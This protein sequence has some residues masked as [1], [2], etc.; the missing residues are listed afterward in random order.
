[1]HFWHY[2]VRIDI[3]NSLKMKNPYV[4]I[5]SFDRQNLFYGVKEISRNQLFVNELVQEISKF[6]AD[7]GSTIVYC[8]TI[9]DVEQVF[10]LLF[11]Y[12]SLRI[13]P[14]SVAQL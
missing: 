13:P 5:G 6:V 9:K 4:A 3:I 10:I 8:L 14:Y 7:A 12:Y 2:R 11:Y 1:M